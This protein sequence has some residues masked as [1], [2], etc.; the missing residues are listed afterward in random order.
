MSAL[1]LVYFYASIVEAKT[2]DRVM[3]I[4]LA[5]I[6][7]AYPIICRVILT[8]AFDDKSSLGLILISPFILGFLFVLKIYKLRARSI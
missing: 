7:I 6:G 5:I 8:V 4:F 1:T 2:T 3:A